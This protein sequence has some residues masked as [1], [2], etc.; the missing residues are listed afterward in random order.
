M[1]D[2]LYLPLTYSTRSCSVGLST[3]FFVTTKASGNSPASS[4]GIPTT[5][6]SITAGW[7]SRILSNSAGGTYGKI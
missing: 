3:V 4:S 6:A 2:I 5:A 7:D 1:I